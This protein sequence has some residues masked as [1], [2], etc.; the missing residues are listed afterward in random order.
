MYGSEQLNTINNATLNAVSRLVTA[1]LDDAERLLKL[2]LEGT[3]KVFAGSVDVLRAM[4]TPSEPGAL[5]AQWP[6][7][8]A[9]NTQKLFEVNREYI[10]VLSH[11]QMEFARVLREEAATIN[12]AV[13]EAVSSFVPAPSIE[14]S[15]PAG[16][17]PVRAKKAG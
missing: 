16:G 1:S 10:E 8:Y 11:T 14:T 4:A 5:F 17:T 13:A 3:Q 12:R 9:E 15:L 7:V 6:Q 2:E